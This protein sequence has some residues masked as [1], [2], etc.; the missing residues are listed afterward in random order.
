MLA[1]PVRPLLTLLRLLPY[2]VA[3]AQTAKLPSAESVF[4]TVSPAVVFI[5]ASGARDGA[6]LGSGVVISYNTVAT[7]CHVIEGQRDI[8]V[9]SQR[10]VYRASLRRADAERDL[11][12][13]TVRGMTA[14][15]VKVASARTLQPGQKVFAVGN[16]RGLELSI[17]DGLV[18][19]LRAPMIQTTAPISPGSSGGGLFDEG[20][21]LVG[22]TT[23]TRKDSQNLNFAIPADWIADVFQGFAIETGSLVTGASAASATVAS[24]TPSAEARIGERPAPHPASQTAKVLLDVLPWGEVYVNGRLRGTTPPLQELELPPGQ[25]RLEIRNATQP[26]YVTSITLEAGASQSIQ[27][28]FSN[29]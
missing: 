16:P 27:H 2:V 15:P 11:C 21:R 6:S 13:L 8:S 12:I 28:K 4:Q 3:L 29:Q 1:R 23:L 5:V 10:R 25:H 24:A 17:S 20:G 22:I 14:H 26:P 9:R 19:A 18:S 7:N